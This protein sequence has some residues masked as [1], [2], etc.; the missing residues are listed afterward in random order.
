M[1]D[2]LCELSA[3]ELLERYKAK[4]LSPVEATRA[5]L[6]RA[7]QVEPKINAFTLID[8]ERALAQAKESEARWA[9]GQPRGRLDG[10]PTSIKDLMLTKGW[11]TLRG[12]LTVDEKG[13]W[14]EDSPAVAR[15]KENGAVLFGKTTTPEF[16]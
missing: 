11:P 5:V 6:A 16:G 14:N 13:P 2:E 7:E 3:V 8:P 10:V 4:T 1:S 12:S 9:K 15:L